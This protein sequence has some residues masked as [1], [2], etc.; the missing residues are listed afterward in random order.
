[1]C[2]NE[3]TVPVTIWYMAE[4]E[5]R[6]AHKLCAKGALAFLTSSA[7]NI[8]CKSSQ[9]N[10]LCG[11]VTGDDDV[12]CLMYRLIRACSFLSASLSLCLSD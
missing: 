9:A 1:M 2:L 4:W 10:H 6:Y 5:V 8:F 3:A 7:P 12:T 11:L